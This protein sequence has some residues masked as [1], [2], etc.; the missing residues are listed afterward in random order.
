ME[1]FPSTFCRNRIRK[2]LDW[3]RNGKKGDE[4]LLNIIVPKEIFKT[5]T[6][7]LMVWSS[8]HYVPIET[9]IKDYILLG[10]LHARFT[11]REAH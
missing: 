4:M 2:N 9:T 7:K 3:K 8:K 11:H 1:K 5:E 6:G 10:D